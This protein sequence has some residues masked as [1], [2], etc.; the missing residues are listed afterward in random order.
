MQGS[1]IAEFF[2]FLHQELGLSVT[3]VKGYRAAL[4]HVFSLI[5]LDLAASSVVS[6]MFRHFKRFCPPWEIWPP[7]W[8]LSLVLR[9]LSRLPFEPFRLASDK[10]MTWN[11]CFLLALASA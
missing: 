7:N 11:T 6:Q 4:D 8:N 10:H 3:A 2:L 1:E 5:G 9:C